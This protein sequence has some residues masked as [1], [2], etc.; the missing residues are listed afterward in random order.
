[1]TVIL[2]HSTVT[3][4]S[5]RLFQI[6]S[7]T[8]HATVSSTVESLAAEHFVVHC[9]YDMLSYTLYHSCYH[10]WQLHAVRVRYAVS[11]CGNLVVPRTRRRIGNRAFSVAAPRAWNRLSTELKLLRST[12]LFRR[13]L[14]TFLLHSVYG[15]QDTDWLWC[16]VGLLVGRGGEILVPQLQ[17]Q[18]RPQLN[19]K[20]E[21]EMVVKV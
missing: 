1:M 8:G 2:S 9:R 20:T 3:T 14:K 13:D 15:H 10:L 17:L 12:D 18:L 16:A 21:I 11:S 4:S 6:R 19:L 5:G 7:A